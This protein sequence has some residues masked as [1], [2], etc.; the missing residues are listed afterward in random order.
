MK[1]VFE[2]K[3]S[4]VRG[5]LTTLVRKDMLAA[6]QRELSPSVR[7]SV[8]SL[9]PVS[10]FVPGVVAVELN[11]AIERAFGMPAVREV[12]FEAARDGVIPLLATA[13][14]T[15]MRIFGVTPPALLSRM[16][17]L[18]A[19]TTRGIRYDY[20]PT[21]SKSGRLTVEYTGSSDLPLALFESTGGGLNTLFSMCSVDGSISKAVW[22]ENG[23]RNAT[24]FTVQWWKKGS[25]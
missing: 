7:D 2:V 13:A 5:I 25:P 23:Q 15:T 1:V 9:P 18:A 24:T 10:S 6:V 20:E 21:D 12:A 22:V 19:T 4:F 3:A 17:T 11:V 16:N 8:S 14:Q